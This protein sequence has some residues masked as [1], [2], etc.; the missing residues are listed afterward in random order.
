MSLF[1]AT[2]SYYCTLLCYTMEKKRPHTTH[3]Y[4]REH[5]YAQMKKRVQ[6]VANLLETHTC[7][8][9]NRPGLHPFALLWLFIWDHYNLYNIYY[10]YLYITA[11]LNKYFHP[12]V[13]IA[14]STE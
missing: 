2:Y 5:G 12:V 13:Y 10:I 8:E 11:T 3:H 14:H 1:I 4:K 6:I 9:Y 7:F